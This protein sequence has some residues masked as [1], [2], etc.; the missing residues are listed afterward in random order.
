MNQQRKTIY[1]LRRQVLFGTYQPELSDDEKKKG[2][3]LPPPPEKSGKLTWQDWSKQLRPVVQRLVDQWWELPAE[4]PFREDGRPEEEKPEPR[5]EPRALRSLIYR[6]FGVFLEVEPHVGDKPK[7]LDWLAEQVGRSFVQQRERLLDILDSLVQEK[8]DEFCPPR[9]HAEDWDQPALKAALKEQ[10]NLDF[11]LKV[12]DLDRDNLSKKVW[13]QIEARVEAKEIELGPIAYFYFTRFFLL[14][15]IDGSWIEHLKAMDHLR[16]GIGLQGYGQ[17]DPKQEYKKQGFEMFGGMLAR[18]NTNVAGKLMRLELA[19]E[20]KPPEVQHKQRKM[21]ERR[22]LGDQRRAVSGRQRPGRGA[23]AQGDRAGRHRAGHL[24]DRLRGQGA[25]LRARAA[26]GRP[27]RTLSVRQRQEVQEVP[28]PERGQRRVAAG[29]APELAVPRA[30]DPGRRG[31][32]VR[33]RRGSRLADLRRVVAAPELQEGYDVADRASAPAPRWRGRSARRRG[34]RARSLPAWPAGPGSRPLQR[35]PRRPRAR[36]A[37][38]PRARCPR[39]RGHARC[40]ARWRTRSDPGRP[41]AA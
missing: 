8:L 11:D 3:E 39:R 33:Q 23:R 7:L 16:E 38:G 15:E 25:D 20:E 34:R 32:E 21:I 24:Q 17:K 35:A 28:R 18:I 12:Q 10:F 9:E 29:S 30:R 27:Q 19:K 26:Q 4:S 5:R 37:G 41:R 6:N 2:I 22:G 1:A 14:E 31:R 40:R 36:R 13:G